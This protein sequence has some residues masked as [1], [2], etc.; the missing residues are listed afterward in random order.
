LHFRIHILC[1][2]FASATAGAFQV[3]T[4]LPYMPPDAAENL[5]LWK[6]IAAKSQGLNLNT[7]DTQATDRN[8]PATWKA[9]VS[10]YQHAGKN[11]MA[12]I[13]RT[14]WNF[15]KVTNKG[16]LEERLEKQFKQERKLNAKI[17]WVMLYGSQP[18]EDRSK[19]AYNY[20][21]EDIQRTRVWLDRLEKDGHPPVRLCWNVRNSSKDEHEKCQDPNVNAILIEG[22]PD[23]WYENR[24]R[25]QEFLKWVTTTPETRGKPLIF[26]VPFN[27]SPKDEDLYFELRKFVSWLSSDKMMGNTDLVR[28][29]DVVFLPIT[30]NAKVPFLPETNETGDQYQNTLAGAA[31]SMIEQKGLFEGRSNPPLTE[32]VLKDRKRN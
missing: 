26:Q 32:Q 3:F 29:D 27:Q 7:S 31:L 22:S 5:K 2:L 14:S 8:T 11:G 20:T 25:R 17:G 15:G 16:T 24:G 9:T 23:K 18:G 28:R 30:Y 10:N 13:P 21:R 1:F 4:A 19:D 12:A 6:E